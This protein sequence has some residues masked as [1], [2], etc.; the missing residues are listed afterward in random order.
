MKWL[1]IGA[2]IVVALYFFAPPQ[3][4]AVKTT[5]TRLWHDLWDKVGTTAAPPANTTESSG[6]SSLQ[7]LA[8]M[9]G[10]TLSEPAPN[11]SNLSENASLTTPSPVADVPA[12]TRVHHGFPDYA[13]TPKVGDTC[14][15]VPVNRDEEC[16]SNPPVNYDGEVNP[17]LHYSNP[18][19]ACCAEDGQCHWN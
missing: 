19:L 11:T 5:A 17:T 4:L 8:A 7:S 12:C 3:Y 9:P 16:L 15:D 10:E 2:L 1:V 13:G 14:I 6:N 18:A